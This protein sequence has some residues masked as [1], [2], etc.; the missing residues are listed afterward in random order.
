MLKDLKINV[1]FGTSL[2]LLALAL[3]FT[4]IRFYGISNLV[5][6]HF[7]SAGRA[8]LVGEINNVFNIIGIAAVIVLLNWI[9]S[10]RLY[11]KDKIFSYVFA[12]IS[13]IVSLIALTAAYLI[14]TI[15]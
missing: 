5:I 6:L 3:F 9:L 8:D 13:M 10:W 4:S 15:N 12:S 7:D 2:V 14:S 1:L 11:L